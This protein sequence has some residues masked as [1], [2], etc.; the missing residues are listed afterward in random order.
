M[1][2]YKIVVLRRGWPVWDGVGSPI[3][4]INQFLVPLSSRETV[5]AITNETKVF[6]SKLPS[7]GLRV[8]NSVP[9]AEEQAD[10]IS[11]RT[12]YVVRS[13]WEKDEILTWFNQTQ[14]SKFKAINPDVQQSA[15]AFRI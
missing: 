11:L 10:G 7:L 1:D 15:Q 13:E 8:V 6:L 12:E 4:H 3:A 5:L 14:A 9:T 2:L